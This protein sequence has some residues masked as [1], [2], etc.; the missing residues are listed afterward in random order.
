MG[1]KTYEILKKN[2]KL[3]VM[4]HKWPK[5]QK[6]WQT[7]WESRRLI[8]VE[9]CKQ[10]KSK[11]L[12]KM[13]FLGVLGYSFVIWYLNVEDCALIITTIID[14]LIFSN[15]WVQKHA[16]SWRISYFLN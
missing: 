1:T 4:S 8:P 10:H 2:I 14:V 9:I 16:K 15:V 6:I 11:L 5:C 13:S 7:V 3:K 12:T